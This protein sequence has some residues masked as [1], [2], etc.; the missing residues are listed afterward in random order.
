MVDERNAMVQY[1]H[2]ETKLQTDIVG[3]IE[4]ADRSYL[5]LPKRERGAGRI[6]SGRRLAVGHVLRHVGGTYGMR[7]RHTQGVSVRVEVAGG[8]LSRDMTGMR[9]PTIISLHQCKILA[10]ELGYVIDRVWGEGS[11]SIRLD[12]DKRY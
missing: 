11:R 8:S 3:G 4:L 9:R 7:I 5:T 12:Q 2:R 10:A 6:W 1:Q